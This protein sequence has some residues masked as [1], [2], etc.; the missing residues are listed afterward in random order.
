M[1]LKDGLYE[2]VINRMISE[3]INLLNDRKL[4]QK[5]NI[6]EEES[7]SILSQYLYAVLKKALSY[8]SDDDKLQRQ[9]DVANKIIMLLKHALNDE[10]ITE[11]LITEDAKMLLSIFDKVN[12][13]YAVINENNIVRP[14]TPLSQSSIFT[15]SSSE[16][17]LVSELKKEI[18]TADRIDMLVSFIKWSGL[19]LI[20][21]EIVEFTKD[22][23][24]RVITTSYMGATDYKAVEFLSMLPNTE[25]K[26]SYDTKRTRL[27]AKSY[28]F[29]RNTGFSTAYIG[30]SNLSNAAI[31]SGLEWN[32]KVT[33]QDMKDIIK[34]FEATFEAYW[35]DKEFTPFYIYEGYKLKNAIEKEKRGSYET[36]EYGFDI[37]PYSYQREILE[38]LKAER[39]IHGKYKNLIVAATGTGKTVIS[40]FDYKNFRKENPTN[41]RLLFI[42]HREEILKQSIAAFRGILKDQN[43]GDLWVGSFEP[44]QIDHLF[45]SIQTFNSKEFYNKTTPDFYDFIIIDEFHHSAA[46]AYQKLIDYYK[47]K[48]L[49]GLTATPERMD[50]KDITEYFD[51][52][53]A[54]EIRLNEA[55]DRKLLCPFQYFGVSDNVDL[56]NLRWSR[57]GYEKN[58]L[59]KLYTHNTKRSELIINSINKYV[60]DIK[61]IIG[62]GFCVSIEHAKYMADFFNKKGI[63]SIALHSG[64]GD[65]ERFRAQ[66]KLKNKEINFIFVVDLYNE[67]VDIP[68]I[69]TVLF[70]RPTE[71]LTVFLQQL[72]RGLRLC[73]GKEC[74]TVLDFIGQAHKKYNFEEKFRALL[75]KCRS[76]LQREIQNGFPNVP[77][78]CYIQLE[79]LSQK[80]VLDNIKSYFN[81]RSSIVNRISTFEEDTGKE[82]TLSNFTEHYHISLKDIYSKDN[83][84]RLCVQ[85]GVKDDFVNADER[86]LTKALLRILHINSKTWIDI[87]LKY[88]NSID[89]IDENNMTE[90]EVKM[91]IM[92]H[93]TIWQEPLYAMNFK[94]LKDSFKRVRENDE[95]F[96][97]LIEI[98]KYNYEKIDFIDKKIDLGFSCPLYLHCTYS[99]DEILS[100][101]GYFTLQKKPSQREGI[102]YIEDKKTDVLFVTLNK[103][104]KDYSPSTLY[105]DYAINEVLFHWQ[106]QSTT[107]H[108]SKTGQR[109]INHKKHGGKVLLF[110]RE[111]KMDSGIASPYYYLGPADYV[112]HS[113]SKPM[114]IIWKLE[115]ELPACLL[116]KANKMIAL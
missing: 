78:G 27:H 57:G 28:M 70:L 90:E 81:N 72:G 40:A 85:A 115:N 86:K 60:S 5:E 103:S 45:M 80:Y 15:G 83:W 96:R 100:A 30:S 4:I 101:L 37:Q 10:S 104:E 92:F 36:F 23:K 63:P 94:S 56:S 19:R 39:E 87:L 48:I 98:L 71:S 24:L 68:E 74:L 22:R 50:G 46:P 95:L 111:Y 31:S 18:L 47:P 52:R 58:D 105:D 64:S 20:A 49:L 76:S 34:K 42:A 55:I 51:G 109:Y 33:E 12:S 11:Y 61:D 59:D 108:S 6:D 32:I 93:Y 26:I 69:N 25:I 88:L 35:H 73:E 13:K 99:R 75:G 89:K 84:S 38:K 97:E 54:A 62:L 21:D 112:S 65:D 102:L 7:S 9:I 77:K 14:V 116:T 106:S 114:N 107:S 67:G 79:K 110:V 2:Q 17:S 82:L 8:I 113:G 91:L 1:E 44:Q 29:Y 3:N 66:E 41:N 43:F 16:P 53:I